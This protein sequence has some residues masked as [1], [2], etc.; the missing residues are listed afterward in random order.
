M[1]SLVNCPGTTQTHPPP[2]PP[3]PPKT[4]NHPPSKCPLYE[5]FPCGVSWRKIPQ[6]TMTPG[7]LPPP[8]PRNISTPQHIDFFR[9][10]LTPLLL[11][12]KGINFE[13]SAEHFIAGAR[14]QSR[15][16]GLGLLHA[17]SYSAHP[18]RN[19]LP[20][21]PV[22][23]HEREDPP[24]LFEERRMFFRPLR[25]TPFTFKKAR[26]PHL[27]LVTLRLVSR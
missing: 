16:N 26:E 13:L 15:L 25:E 1:S 3:P 6:S 7:L 17:P 14:Q 19:H 12:V 24:D 27:R 18:L 22:W 21:P 8:P 9:V 4:P 11:G 5:P 20:I 23:R 10:V 2:P